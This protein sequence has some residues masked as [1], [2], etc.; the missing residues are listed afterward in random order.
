MRNSN[1]QGPSKMLNLQKEKKREGSYHVMIEDYKGQRHKIMLFES[2][3]M[4]V[5]ELKTEII[6]KNS[7]HYLFIF[8]G[9]NYI[10]GEKKKTYIILRKPAQEVDDLITDTTHG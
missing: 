2:N 7:N 9:L 6:Q 3:F 8:S 1:A 5:E 4:I 10:E